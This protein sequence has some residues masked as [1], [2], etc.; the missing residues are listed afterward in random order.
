MTEENKMKAP[1]PTCRGLCNVINH[2]EKNSEWEYQV[3]RHNLMYGATTHKLLECCGCNTVFYLK[4]SW[5]SEHGDYDFE[6]QFIPFHE[7]ETVPAAGKFLRPE[8]L[9][10]IFRLD[11]TLHSILVE[12][13]TAYENKA[14][15]LASTG[16]R[17]A[18][19]RTSHFIGIPQHLN[20]E[21]K[22]KE[23][24]E[25]GYVSETEREQLA[26]VTNAGNAAA[27]RG[28]TPDESDFESLLRTTEKFIHRVVLR[29]HRI[30]AIGALIPKRQKKGDKD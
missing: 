30:E 13:Y 18:F 26:V 19:D 16:L 1:C 8:W 20:M 4:D 10:Q 2:G 6:G 9:E 14:L 15:I 25:Q 17:I 5:N 11:F 29:D 3:D 28:W 23:V 7:I 27:H 24:F 22:V 12:V 21:Q